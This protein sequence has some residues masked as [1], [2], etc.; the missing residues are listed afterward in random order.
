MFHGCY[1]SVGVPNPVPTI[2]TGGQN[3]YFSTKSHCYHCSFC[4]GGGPNSIANFDGGAMAGF[5]PSLD[6]PL[7]SGWIDELT[8]GRM[9]ERMSAWMGESI[10]KI[11]HHSR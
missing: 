8:N 2:D 3:P 7:V 9:D 4:P 10:N 6:P 1:F 11:T 5:A